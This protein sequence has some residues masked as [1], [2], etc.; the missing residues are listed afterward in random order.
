MDDISLNNIEKEKTEAFLSAHF[1]YALH[2]RD[3][4]DLDQLIRIAQL[5][6][7]AMFTQY[8]IN[9]GANYSDTKEQQLLAQAF[10][11]SVL[12]GLFELIDTEVVEND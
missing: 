11:N 8:L 5:C 9:K 12:R 7:C 2:G 6:N 10:T 3:A 4:T 1:A